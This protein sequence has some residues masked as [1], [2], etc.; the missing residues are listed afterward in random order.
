MPCK[1][2]TAGEAKSIGVAHQKLIRDRRAAEDADIDLFGRWWEGLD[3]TLSKSEVREI[4]H[5]TA[6]T[7][8]EKY[9]WL[10]NMGVMNLHH[11]GIFFDGHLGGVVVYTVEYIENLGKWDSYGFTG[12]IILL[13]RGAC[14][15]WTPVGTAS[16]LIRRSMKLLPPKYEI[17]TCTVDA[18]AGEIGTIYQACGFYYTGQLSKGGPIMSADV[19]GKNV[20]Q[21]HLRRIY[22][23]RG[24]KALENVKDGSI[25]NIKAHARKKR[26]FAFRGSR[27]SVK[28]HRLA[29]AHL[30]KPYPKRGLSIG[31]TDPIGAS[32]V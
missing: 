26:Y 19:N 16:R 27:S 4:D 10:G 23:T 9:E 29:I 8:I 31:R 6:K 24:Q 32:L 1:S 20:S 13:S 21:R 25:S 11:F 2:R 7:I 28:A 17:V 30:I 14:S 22:G 18:E 5:A 12:K 3:L 15:H